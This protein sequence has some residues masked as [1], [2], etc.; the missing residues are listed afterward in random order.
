MSYNV[1]MKKQSISNNWADF[2]SDTIDCLI[3]DGES[4]ANKVLDK[5]GVY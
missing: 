4:D 2:T 5:E 1:K 3:K